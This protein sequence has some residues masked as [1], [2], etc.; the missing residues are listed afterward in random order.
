MTPFLT[1][2]S[3]SDFR[4]DVYPR[5]GDEAA[6]MKITTKC[7]PLENKIDR[8]RRFKKEYYKNYWGWKL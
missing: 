2:H 3:I 1:Y 7:V 6:A 8:S 5:A 4:D